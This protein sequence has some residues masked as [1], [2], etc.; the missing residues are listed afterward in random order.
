MKLTA[1]DLEM[2]GRVRE[3]RNGYEV[4]R[5]TPSTR[6]AQPNAWGHHWA[7]GAAAV[8]QYDEQ[9]REQAWAM[10]LPEGFPKPALAVEHMA[11]LLCV[12]MAYEAQRAEQSELSAQQ[13]QEGELDEK[14]S[15]TVHADRVAVAHATSRA[16]ASVRDQF[17][18]G[19]CYK[20]EG[21][22]ALRGVV[23]VDAH[24]SPEQSKSEAWGRALERQ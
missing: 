8:V 9:K 24:K 21:Y 12:T 10:N 18:Y 20:H 5:G 17:K 1:A 3:F 16:G 13:R 6:T 19:L 11:L 23:K 14:E 15:L 22:K 7:A 4:K 2:R